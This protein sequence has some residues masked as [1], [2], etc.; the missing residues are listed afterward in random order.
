[1]SQ[2]TYSKDSIPE[3]VAAE[4]DELALVCR[5][6]LSQFELVVQIFALMPC[7]AVTGKAQ[8]SSRSRRSCL[9]LSCL[10]VIHMQPS[11]SLQSTRALHLSPVVERFI[12]LRVEDT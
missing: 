6:N 5:G 8:S 7:F 9:V 12:L 2:L 3:F 10:L 1:M 11:S 4:E